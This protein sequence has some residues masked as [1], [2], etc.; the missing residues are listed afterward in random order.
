MLVTAVLLTTIH[1]AGFAQSVASLEEQQLYLISNSHFGD[2]LGYT[3]GD[4]RKA[5]ISRRNAAGKSSRWYLDRQ[6]DGTFKIISNA[7]IGYVLEASLSNQGAV[8]L[9]RNGSNSA[10][11]QRWQKVDERN[12]T[13]KLRNM[14]YTDRVLDASAGARGKVQ[15]WR[16]LGNSNQYVP[17]AANQRWRATPVPNPPRLTSDI[18]FLVTPID[19]VSRLM[20]S[21]YNTKNTEEMLVLTENL[22]PARFRQAL[23]ASGLSASIAAGNSSYLGVNLAIKKRARDLRHMRFAAFTKAELNLYFSNDMIARGFSESY[24]NYSQL[25]A[26]DKLCLTVKTFSDQ[27][28]ND[29][30]QVYFASAF[31]DA[32]EQTLLKVMNCLSCEQVNR[33][34]N[35]FTY[36]EFNY[37]FDGSENTRFKQLYN[38]CNR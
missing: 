9:G 25:S 33:L 7:E 34:V 29:I 16:D 3:V 35:R 5:E 12:G 17:G 24:P 28:L 8:Q 2:D 1:L 30:V 13:F 15:L 36:R 21:L 6:A 26:N 19:I 27:D 37:K 10:S 38:R 22:T 31:H 23:D 20:V 11:H 4:G 14:R 32:E 18:N